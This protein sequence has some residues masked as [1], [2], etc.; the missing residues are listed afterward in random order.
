MDT[1]GACTVYIYI[2]TCIHIYY[3]YMLCNKVHTTKI[4]MQHHIRN[5]E[6]MYACTSKGTSFIFCVSCPLHNLVVFEKIGVPDEKQH[7][8]CHLEYVCFAMQAIINTKRLAC[9]LCTRS[10]CFDSTTWFSTTISDHSP[11]SENLSD[12]QPLHQLRA[13][14][15]ALPGDPP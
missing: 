11:C 2:Y 8:F 1:Y 7:W 9:V 6:T 5:S 10:P 13:L 3:I 14:Q 4:C 15:R 12:Q